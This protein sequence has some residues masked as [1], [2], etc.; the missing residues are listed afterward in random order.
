MEI[1]GVNIFTG[2]G[3]SFPP[4]KFS[5]FLICNKFYL[6][7]FFWSLPFFTFTGEIATSFSRLSR[8]VQIYYCCCSEETFYLQSDIYYLF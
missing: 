1:V 2:G 6:F 5:I 4:C 3:I 7:H 8:Y